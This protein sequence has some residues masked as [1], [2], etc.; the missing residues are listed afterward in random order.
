M[1]RILS[2]GNALVVE[3]DPM[4]R[5]LLADD[6]EILRAGLRMLVEAQDDM[7]VIGEASTGEETVAHVRALRPDVAVLDLTMPGM[8]GL[9]AA[10]TL[11]GDA[12]ATKIVVLS[13]HGDEAYVRELLAAGTNGYVLK[14]SGS[15]ELLHAIRAA[16]RNEQYLDPAL[17]PEKEGRPEISG[18]NTDVTPR[19]REVLRSTAIGLSNKEIAAQLSISFRT[20]EVHKTNGMRKLKLEGRADVVRYAMLHGWLKDP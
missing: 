2:R 18:V 11:Q 17:R 1:N 20:V 15:A 13:R 3:D 14:H 9:K 4:I 19:E 7:T 6:H 16:A 8:G 12:E 5:V 10:R